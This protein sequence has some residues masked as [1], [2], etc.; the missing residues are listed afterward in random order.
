MT[1]DQM[2]RKLANTQAVS[3][4]F[5]CGSLTNDLIFDRCRWKMLRGTIELERKPFI[6]SGVLS[7]GQM[8]K[9]RVRILSDFGVQYSLK[10]CATLPHVQPP[11]APDSYS[12][13]LAKK[14]GGGSFK[15]RGLIQPKFATSRGGSFSRPVSVSVQRSCLN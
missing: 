9:F 15:G 10:L 11:G 7:C 2:E 12:S 14:L 13:S 8:G 1:Q 6:S 5:N 4:A 3:L